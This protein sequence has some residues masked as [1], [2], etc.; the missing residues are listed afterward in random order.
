MLER[1]APSDGEPY[2]RPAVCNKMNEKG[3]QIMDAA[4]GR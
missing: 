1:N 3:F 4:Q 2:S